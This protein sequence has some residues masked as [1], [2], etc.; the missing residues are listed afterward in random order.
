MRVQGDDVDTLDGE[1]NQPNPG[2]GYEP[3]K[4][5]GLWSLLSYDQRDLIIEDE[6][7]EEKRTFPRKGDEGDFGRTVLQ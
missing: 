6:I 1:K 3:G 2:L 5:P 4:E 7:L